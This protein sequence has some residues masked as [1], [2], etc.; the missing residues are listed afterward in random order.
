MCV[1]VKVISGGFGSLTACYIKRWL[2][3]SLR[4]MCR[5]G[6]WRYGMCSDVFSVRNKRR[7]MTLLPPTG[8]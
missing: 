6:T 5:G 7:K 1:C 2:L 8:L 3:P 4:E